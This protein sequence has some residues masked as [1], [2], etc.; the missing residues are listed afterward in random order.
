MNKVIKIKVGSHN[1]ISADEE[2]NGLCTGC[3]LVKPGTN[4]CS[5]YE[6]VY[7][8]FTLGHSCAHNKHIFI[9]NKN[10]DQ[11]DQV[12]QKYTVL[13]VINAIVDSDYLIISGTTPYPTD[14]VKVETK[15]SKLL[16]RKDDPSYKEFLRLKK[17]YE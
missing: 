5:K 11:I 16:Q 15:V 1:L 14:L 3:F 10:P 9:I 7:D 8:G 4:E 12:E 2:Y 6:A 13:E 17:L